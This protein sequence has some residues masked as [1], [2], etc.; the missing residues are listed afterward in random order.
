MTGRSIR[1]ATQKHVV[2][3]KRRRSKETNTLSMKKDGGEQRPA[4]KSL[5]FFRS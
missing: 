5:A 4:S 2:I 3:G 1:A